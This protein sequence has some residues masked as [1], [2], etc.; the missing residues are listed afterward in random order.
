MASKTP[1]DVNL[2]LACMRS[3]LNWKQSELAEAAGTRG[4]TI[5]DFERGNRTFS[6][7]KL[8]E[9]AGVLGLTPEAAA[10]ARAFVRSM[11]EQARPPGHHGP[12]AAEDRRRIERVAAQAGTLAA[13]FTRSVLSSVSF[14]ARILAARDEAR[15]L[16]LKMRRLSPSQRRDLV[17]KDLK[18]RSWGLCELICKESI[19][20]AADNADRARDLAELALR[21]ADLAPGAA[22]W[23]QRLQGYAWAHVGNARRVGGDLPGAEKAFGRAGK[24]WE[25]GE[26]GDPG[27]LDEAQMLSLEASL[28]I[29]Q[30]RLAEATVLLDRALASAPSTLRPNLLIA[31]ARALEWAGAY[32]NA[33]ATLAEVAPLVTQEDEPRRL[34]MLRLNCAWNL[35]HL[36]RYEKAEAFLPEI[37]VL[38]T[39]LGN[40]LDTLRL[41]WLEGRISAG[42]G[43]TEQALT[44]LSQVRSEFADRSISY[45]AALATLELAILQLEQGRTREVKMLARQMGPI[46][47]VQ[48]VHREALAALKLFCEAAEQE[49]VTVELAR[50]VTEYLYRAQH[51]PSLRFEPL[52]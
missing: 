28:R 23:R 38:T 17:E 12:D 50:R 22:S 47:R 1:S 48:G 13:D 26:E 29:D 14:E 37:R 4:T 11:E 21:I 6:L 34:W 8:T 51:N 35:T 30:C 2:A 42:L 33:L 43:R 16:W 24:L 32:E 10:Q 3:A 31:K 5:S 20:A 45:D 41:R 19:K 46:F 49:W 36:A 40:E 44:A 52:S 39:R 9:L 15:L 27:I 18:F 7:E 25:M